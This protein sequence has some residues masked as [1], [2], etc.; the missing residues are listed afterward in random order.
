MKIGKRRRVGRP[1][2][3]R[4]LGTIA[5]LPTRRDAQARLDEM[6]ATVNAASSRPESS[7]TFGRFVEQQW[8]PLVFPTFKV[9]TQHG[10]K[11]VLAKHVLP[12]RR[13]GQPS[14][15]RRER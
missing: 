4:L 13:D 6:L 9:S 12:P 2:V 7:V 3:S 11:N 5:E 8:T 1:L 14:T 10:Y 15:W